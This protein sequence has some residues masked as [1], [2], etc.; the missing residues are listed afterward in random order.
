MTIFQ[1]FFDESGKFKDKRVI[2]FCGLC[3]PPEK[4]Q[5]FEDDWKGLLRHYGLTSLT[6]KRALRR[7]IKFSPTAEAKSV[8]ER[9]A[10]LE[11]FAQCIR[12]HFELGVALAVDVDA[13]KKWPLHA[14]KKIGGSDDPYY[15]AFISALLACTKY[16][17]DDDRVSMVCDDD[18]ETAMNCYG[19]FQRARFLHPE[20]RKKLVSITFADDA[21]FV[22]L[23]GADLLASLCRLEAR[24]HF[25]KDYYEHRSLFRSLTAPS[26]DGGMKWCVRF[27]GDKWLDY[28]QS[29]WKK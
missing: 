6:M 28:F 18:Q 13:Y 1:A 15:L 21:E 10:V 3:S 24:Q 2:S 5:E 16:I 26:S 25:H 9:N 19:I 22:A 27:Y 20:Y 8:E 4:V 7:K 14:K 11:P 12:K 29:K 17:C 23:Q